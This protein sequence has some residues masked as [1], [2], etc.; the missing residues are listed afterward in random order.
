MFLAI[1]KVAVGRGCRTCH[2]ELERVALIYGPHLGQ[3]NGLV[4]T[5]TDLDAPRAA[6]QLSQSTTVSDD[7]VVD[8]QVVS[9][10]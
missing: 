1:E 9:G 8:L 5:P 7:D 2:P 3:A 6:S 4:E 10:G